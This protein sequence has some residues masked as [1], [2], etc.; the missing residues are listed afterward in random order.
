[1]GETVVVHK[2]EYI[3]NKPIK[4]RQIKTFYMPIINLCGQIPDEECKDWA[5]FK[6]PQP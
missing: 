2:M 1:M 6:T 5:H 4:L 3:I